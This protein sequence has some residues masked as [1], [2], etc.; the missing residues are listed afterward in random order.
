[1]TTQ[2]GPS[3]AKVERTYPPFPFF[4]GCGRSGTS[5]LRAI[6]DSHPAM[7]VPRDT[8]FILNLAER[9]ERFELTSGFDVPGFVRELDR[10]FDFER[11]TVGIAEIKAALAADPPADYSDAVRRIFALSAAREGKALYGNKSPV[12]VRRLDMLDALF[13]EG[14]FV[15]IIR[16]GR[17]VALSYLQV[18]FGP[19]TVEGGALRWKRHVTSGR[20]AGAIIGPEKYHEVRYERLIAD[21]EAVARDLCAFIGI[22]F[23]DRMLRYYERTADLYPGKETP[24]HHRNLAKPP[25]KGMRDWRTEMAPSDVATFEVIAGDLLSE[26]GYERMFPAPGAGA[27]IRTGTRLAAEQ[28]RGFALRARR[29][30]KGTG[31]KRTVGKA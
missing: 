8:Y 24:V 25:T 15:H 7:N 12:H 6:F 16:D 10:Q 21:T 23:D 26:L 27:K 9:R 20:A 28:V 4:V 31:A 5:L 22:D 13:P 11:W 19:T 2:T 17:D 29:R 3:A 14:R 18:D 30:A 1:M